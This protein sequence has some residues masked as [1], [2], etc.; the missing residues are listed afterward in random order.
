MFN[1]KT[2]T[3]VTLIGLLAA[4]GGGSGGGGAPRTVF[5][6][7]TLESVAPGSST[8]VAVGLTQSDPSGL[9]DGTDLVSGTLDRVSRKL[10]IDGVV[11]DG[12][13]QT[14]SGSWTDGTTTVS[15]SNLP[16]FANTETYD[17]FVP[18]TVEQ[19]GLESQYIFGVVSRTQDLPTSPDTTAFTYNGVAR[20]EGILGSDG[21]APGTKIGSD[22]RLSLTADFAR[23]LVDVVIDRL[24]ATGMPFDTVR[25]DNLVLSIGNN[26]TFERNDTG[27]ITFEG[28]TPSLG[29]PTT[30]SASG[31]F[32]GGAVNEIVAPSEAGG[33]FTVNGQNGNVIYGIFAGDRVR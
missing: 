1:F 4:C 7:Q 16:I 26:A 27:F 23:G 24:N 2:Y 3:A 13:F 9:P 32:F 21:T 8:I 17:F 22:G 33:V 30:E 11:V 31:A 14:A 25:I 20:V 5:N 18:V 10:S 12:V 15:P 19:G 6:Y 29:A 28:G